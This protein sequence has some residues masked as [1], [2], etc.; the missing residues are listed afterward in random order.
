MNNDL[1]DNN[2]ESHN[3]LFHIPVMGT[4]FTIDTPIRVAKYGIASVISLVD[5]V[6]IEQIRKVYCHKE[7]ETYE[8]IKSGDEDARARRITEYLNLVDR[9]VKRQVKELQESPFEENSEITKYYEMLPDSDLK[10]KYNEMTRMSDG[11]DKIKKQDELRKLAVPGSI[12]VNIMTKLD[13][14]NHRNGHTLSEE[15]N[16]AIAALR[17][18]AQSNLRS[19]IIF[20]AG[21]NKQLYSHMTKFKDFFVDANNIIKKKII[22]KVSDYRSA[23][24]QGKFLARKGLW[25]SEYRVESGLNCGGHTFATKGYLLG[26]ILEEFKKRKQEL[27]NY[28]HEI[29][30]S[31]AKALHLPV[32]EKP[33]NLRITVQGGIG[34]SEEQNFLINHYCV[35]GTGWGTPFLLAQDV[36]SMDSDSL[37]RLANATRNDAVLSPNSPLCLP[38]WSLRTSPSEELRR[39]HIADGRPGSACPKGFL[40][41]NTEFSEHPLCVASRAYQTLKLKDISSGKL[42]QKQMEFIKEQVLAKSCIC[43]DLGGT[44]ARVHRIDEKATP[45]ICCGPNIGYFSK[46][47]DLS[48]MISHIY[49][50]VSLLNETPRPHMF[51]EELKIYIEH[52]VNE[53][54]KLKLHLLPDQKLDY[55]TEFRDNLLDGIEYYRGLASELI[56]EQRD[57]FLQDLAALKEQITKLSPNIVQPEITTGE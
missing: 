23:I 1:S 40:T 11:P 45:A 51:I 3:H 24:I 54:H 22:L 55:F 43:H 10:R 17:G 47:T 16:D 6:L 36:V 9:I 14:T 48:N 38:F 29:Y 50:R 13:K 30:S 7:G 26:P 2:N 5:D 33:Q 49:G 46:I 41:N 27:L 52:M 21:L 25:V 53:L 44:A 18:Y 20:S 12:D 42:N 35:D 4:G 28:L 31:A 39:Q 57:R 56:D 37:N 32:S 34:T 8:E 19:A 15:F